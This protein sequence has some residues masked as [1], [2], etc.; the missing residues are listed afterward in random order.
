MK[1]SVDICLVCHRYEHIE[2]KLN[3]LWEESKKVGLEF[4]PSNTEKIRVNRIVKGD[5]RL[6]G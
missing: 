2:M 4:N 5:F 3:D 6:N 1:Y